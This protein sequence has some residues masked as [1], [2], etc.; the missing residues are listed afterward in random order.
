MSFYSNLPSQ[1]GSPATS[2][3]A[4]TPTLFEVL[5]SNEI[6][7]L[8]PSSIR[9]ILTKYWIQRHPTRFN[10]N[11]NNWFDEWFQLVLISA[12]QWYHLTH[13]DATFIDKFYGLQQYN[14]NSVLADSYDSAIAQNKKWPKL[15]RLTRKQ[16][17]V[18]MTQD[19]ILP[20][21]KGKLD[22]HYERMYG[23]Q[24]SGTLFQLEESNEQTGNNDDTSLLSKLLVQLKKWFLKYYPYMTKLS[25]L[26]NLLIKLRF[27]SQKYGSHTSL[28][29]YIFNIQY[30]RGMR[31]LET[32][33]DKPRA[34]H[35][36]TNKKIRLNNIYLI[37]KFNKIFTDLVKNKLL[38]VGSTMFPSF[39]F[40]LKVYQW[41]DNANLTTKLSNSINQLNKYIPKP[42]STNKEENTNIQDCPICHYE[43][44]NPCIIETGCIACYPCMVQYLKD[45]KGKCP[46]TG[47][48]L[49]GY[50]EADPKNLGKSI[51]RLLV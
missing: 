32:D 7:D 24:Q 23:S 25:S 4:S 45:N 38:W 15:L 30:T 33:D 46:M 39:I 31:E 40:L 29:E 19:V 1:G 12:V 20:Y 13:Y 48:I 9:Y 8:F 51:R 35:F 49:L 3:E 16:I 5:S 22:H 28:L 10:I 43:I 6:N 27:L 37:H 18:L 44:T 14:G 34:P 42:P 41:W 11:L 50:N 26:L 2:T 47:C 21:L 17:G 36:D